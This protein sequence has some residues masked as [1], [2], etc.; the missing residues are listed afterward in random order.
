VQ[1]RF[2]K[3]PPSPTHLADCCCRLLF[4]VLQLG[5]RLMGKQSVAPDTRVLATPSPYLHRSVVGFFIY[6][7]TVAFLLNNNTLSP[8][9]HHHERKKLKKTV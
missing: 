3:L 8:T 6:T 2:F 7:S 5:C 4:V 9:K 1:H